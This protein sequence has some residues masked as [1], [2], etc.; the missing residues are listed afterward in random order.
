[1]GAT[2]LLVGTGVAAAG[3]LAQGVAAYQQGAKLVEINI[4]GTP[5]SDFCV[6]VLRAPAGEIMP[7]LVERVKQL[8][9]AQE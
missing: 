8:S 7:G 4:L 3:Q 2:A 5:L 9:A 1:M 6:A